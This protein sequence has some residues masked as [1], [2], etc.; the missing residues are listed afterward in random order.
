M[1]VSNYFCIIRALSWNFCINI[2]ETMKE[3]EDNSFV[4]CWSFLMA[5]PAHN[6]RNM[7]VL[8]FTLSDSIWL[9]KLILLDMEKWSSDEWNKVKVLDCLL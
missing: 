6:E 1:K 4:L 3:D 5:F 8:N 2:Q 9:I 7:L